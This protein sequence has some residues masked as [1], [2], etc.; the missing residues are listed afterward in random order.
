M[1][2]ITLDTVTEAQASPQ[3][4]AIYEDIKSTMGVAL[5]NLV[6]RHLAIKPTVLRWSW[7]TLKP[8]YAQ[9]AIPEAAWSLRCSVKPPV[10][11]PLSSQELAHVTRE[12]GNV[13]VL[14]A[15]LHTYER[16]N[17]QN[18]VAMCFLQ[19]CIEGA[20]GRSQPA[21]MKPQTAHNVE[22]ND[23]VDQAAIPALPATD[24]LTADLQQII[25]E[26]TAIWVPPE[27]RG[28]TPSVFRHIALWP[29][30]L[31]L[32]Q[33]R[34][35]EL[36]K[37]GKDALDKPTQDTIALANAHAAALPQQNNISAKLTPAET[38]WL[39]QTLDLFI[40]GMIARGVII[41]PAMRAILSPHR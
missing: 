40:N 18:L 32:Y 22:A 34:L 6:W 3:T 29:D 25:S 2:D 28:I 10:L 26:M 17:A 1:S 35:C 23:R 37:P 38:L 20:P 16:G 9:H 19:R 27:Y 39:R 33:E 8:H 11:G 4:R 21:A 12:A 14:D 7:D 30:T 36:L 31:T 5:V 24:T 41:V 15:V 13:A